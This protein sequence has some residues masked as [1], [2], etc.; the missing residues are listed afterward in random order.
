MDVEHGGQTERVPRPSQTSSN[1]NNNNNN[2]NNNTNNDNNNNNNTDKSSGNEKQTDET[3][4]EPTD[5]K[6]VNADS[7]DVVMTPAHTDDVVTEPMSEMHISNDKEPEQQ[8]DKTV[9]DKENGAKEPEGSEKEKGNVMLV[10]IDDEGN[11]TEMWTMMDKNDVETTA[12]TNDADR[13]VATCV[14]QLE[15]MGFDNCNGWLTKLAMV[16]QGDTTRVIENLGS[17]PV[18]SQRLQA[19]L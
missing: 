19:A 1:N 6:E 16:H 3:P 10:D 4:K 13:Q 9:G 12:K 18:Y 8:A 2:D 11:D 14:E 7:G 17:D 15:A 5:A